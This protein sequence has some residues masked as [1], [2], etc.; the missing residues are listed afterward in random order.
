MQ[1]GNMTN[2]GQGQLCQQ[3]ANK[4]AQIDKRDV[5]GSSTVTGRLDDEVRW[6]LINIWQ[7]S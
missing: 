4:Q 3:L 1:A 7:C 5:C 2:Q 6:Y